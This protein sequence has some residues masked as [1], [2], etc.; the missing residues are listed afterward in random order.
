MANANT[1]LKRKTEL[2]FQAIKLTARTTAT[3]CTK[4]STIRTSEHIC[5]IEAN[6]ISLMDANPVASVRKISLFFSSGFT[7][8][9]RENRLLR[10]PLPFFTALPTRH[11]PTSDGC[12]AAAKP[13]AAQP[14][15]RHQGKS[16]RYSLIIG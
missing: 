8:Y 15:R 9:V 10:S 2:L 12:R 3:D 16:A 7:S 14:P 5:R 11:L 4:A 13:T 1:L 6:V